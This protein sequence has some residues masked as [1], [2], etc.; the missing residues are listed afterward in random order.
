[1]SIP[2]A[3]TPFP[4]HGVNTTP[5]GSI[6]IEVWNP[7]LVS[8]ADWRE[9]RDKRSPDPAIPATDY[10]RYLAEDHHRLYGRP[11]CIGRSYF[12]FLRRA[13][14]RADQRVLDFGCGAGRIGIWL[15]PFLQHGHYVGVDHHW[16]ALDAFARY[17]IPLHGLGESAPRLVLDDSLDI[18]RLDERFDAILDCYVSFHLGADARMRLYRGFAQALRPGGRIF[19]PHAPTLDEGQLSSLGLA[20]AD[21]RLQPSPFLAGHFPEAKA[22]DHWHLIAAAPVHADSAG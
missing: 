6:A 3:H 13:G 14:L 15:I 11:W 8:A 7:A 20:I 17:E 18:A 4:G 16:I 12:E 19:L 21:A 1:M 5:P 2:P 10:A 22:S 9:L